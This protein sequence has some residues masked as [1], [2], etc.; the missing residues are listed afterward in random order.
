M[1]FK[2]RM[3]IALIRFFIVYA[4]KAKAIKIGGIKMV[5]RKVFKRVRMTEE[6]TT[7]GG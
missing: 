1:Y 7:G 6:E 5:K 4:G 2:K 3:S